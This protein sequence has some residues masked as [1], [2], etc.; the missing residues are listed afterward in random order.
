MQTNN[1]RTWQ[2]TFRN[3]GQPKKGLHFINVL[4]SSSNIQQRKGIKNLE[5]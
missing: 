1:N 5:K 3:E 4:I 2:V